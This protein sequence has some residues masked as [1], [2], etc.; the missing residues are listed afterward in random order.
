MP[1]AVLTNF[2]M[3]VFPHHG[4]LDGITELRKATSLESPGEVCFLL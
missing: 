1:A 4:Q 3:S 2:I